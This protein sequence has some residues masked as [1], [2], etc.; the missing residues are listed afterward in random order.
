[1]SIE[2]RLGRLE[3]EQGGDGGVITVSVPAGMSQDEA[4]RRHFGE[5]GEPQNA[6]VVLIQRFS[7]DT[8]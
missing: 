2:R 6:L 4:I 7:E 3:P 1:M 8:G 5:E